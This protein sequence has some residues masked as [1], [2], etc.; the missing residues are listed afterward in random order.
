MNR[1]TFE[2]IENIRESTKRGDKVWTEELAEEFGYS[3]PEALR[4]AFRRHRKKV[5]TKEIKSSAKILLFDIETTPILAFV[6]GLWNQNVYTNQIV[7]DWH[8]A[9]WAAKWLFDDNVYSDVLTVDEATKHD[10]SRIAESMWNLLN[11]ADI[12]VTHNGDRFDIK[13]LNTRFLCNG[14]IPPTHFRSID[15]Y[16]V[17]KSYFRFSSNKLDYINKTLGIPDKIDTDFNLWRR[18]YFGDKA[19]L[20]EMATYNENDVFILEET[21]LKMR[22]YIRNFPN[23]NLW[24]DGLVSVCRNCGSRNIY[25]SGYYY[26]NLNKYK[27]WRCDDCGAIG[28]NRFSM[29]STEKRRFLIV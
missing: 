12:V 11:E 7:Q 22:P 27:G 25:W 29:T 10:D 3:S 2:Y 21:F 13:A 28:R 4:S 18:V 15:T 23:L 1:D 5:N 6:W 16:K 9:S 20:R 8:L 24:E 19:A 14:F 26:T 17:A